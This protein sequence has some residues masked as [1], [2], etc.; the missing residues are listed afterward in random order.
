[1]TNP[2]S[3][4]SDESSQFTHICRSLVLDQLRL[5]GL[6]FSR[7]FSS[8]NHHTTRQDN[9]AQKVAFVISIPALSAERVREDIFWTIHERVRRPIL[10]STMTHISAFVSINR[11]LSMSL[12]VISPLNEL[13]TSHPDLSLS[14]GLMMKP[15]LSTSA[16][17]APLARP[18][19]S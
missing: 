4:V 9:F 11:T 16:G 3:L 14:K 7:R 8:R 5:E 15:R 13:F 6:F 18:L 17:S 19:R 10:T 2:R 12:A 1:M